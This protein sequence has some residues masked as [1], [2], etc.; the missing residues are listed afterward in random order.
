MGMT[1]DGGFVPLPSGK[2]WKIEARW[3]EREEG[4]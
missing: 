4:G 1:Q 2:R 3:R